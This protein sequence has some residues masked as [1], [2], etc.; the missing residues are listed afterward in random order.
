MIINLAHKGLPN[1]VFGVFGSYGW[2]GGGVKG[3]LEHLR[4]NNWMLVGQPVEVQFSAK[5]EDFERLRKL[6]L[7]MAAAVKAR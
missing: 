3:I 1:R 6:A 2:S 4:K 5:G 7:E